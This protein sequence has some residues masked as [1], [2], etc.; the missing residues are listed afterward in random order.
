MRPRDQ[1]VL[2]GQL[3]QRHGAGPVQR[4]G[5]RLEMVGP[6]EIAKV[7]Q[8]VEYPVVLHGTLISIG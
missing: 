4:E 6:G 7:R 1:R 8:N 2:R 5:E 3:D